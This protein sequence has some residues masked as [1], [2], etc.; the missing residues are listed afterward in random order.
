MNIENL[1]ITVILITVVYVLLAD[2]EKSNN[3]SVNK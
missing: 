1:L 3:N 2:R